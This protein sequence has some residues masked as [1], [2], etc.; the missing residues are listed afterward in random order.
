MHG[1]Q[2]R[3]SPSWR[4]RCLAAQSHT[5]STVD[6]NAGV[7]SPLR[8]GTGLTNPTSGG[9]LKSNGGDAMLTVRG[10]GALYSPSNG[11]PIFGTLPISM[12]GTGVT[13]Q[14][15]LLSLVADIV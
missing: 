9:L 4:R 12:G 10:T 3:T 5:H 13:T 11:N 7:L 6:I 14:S 8:G 1:G 15:A 2:D